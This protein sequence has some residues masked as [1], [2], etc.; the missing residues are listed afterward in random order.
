MNNYRVTISFT[1]SAD[2][3]FSAKN[4]MA[5]LHSDYAFCSRVRVHFEPENMKNRESP[6]PVNLE[7]VEM[8]LF[9]LWTEGELSTIE[10]KTILYKLNL[11]D[12]DSFE[13]LNQMRTDHDMRRLER[14]E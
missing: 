5:K 7:P 2:N 13:D 8:V 4:L 1:F 9:A 3:E 10:Y 12:A 11:L 6:V 14:E